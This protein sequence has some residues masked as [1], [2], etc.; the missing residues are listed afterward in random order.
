MSSG[1]EG[2]VEHHWQLSS[3]V[4]VIQ[5]SPVTFHD[6]CSSAGYVAMHSLKKNS[7]SWYKN[8]GP[9]PARM[10]LGAGLITKA[11]IHFLVPHYYGSRAPPPL[12][13]RPL[14]RLCLETVHPINGCPVHPHL[15]IHMRWFL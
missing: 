1:C 8:K 11:P 9:A 6:G 7:L 15:E 14:G 2:P 10:Q 3:L 12:S 5:S 13:S 4:L